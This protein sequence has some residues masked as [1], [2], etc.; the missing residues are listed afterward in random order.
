MP[1]YNT[2]VAFFEIFFVFPFFSRLF[3]V[4]LVVQ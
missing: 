4:L 1:A 3:I 2:L